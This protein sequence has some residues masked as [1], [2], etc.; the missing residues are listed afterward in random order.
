M[1][2]RRPGGAFD[3]VSRGDV[4]GAREA[5]S[6]GARA[7]PDTFAGHS[8]NDYARKQVR[9]WSLCNY[10]AIAN[11]PLIPANTDCLFDQ[12]VPTD[13]HG[14]Y[15]IVVSLPQDR[16]RNAI[17]RC[18]VAWMNW[19]TKGDDVPGGHNRLISLTMRNQLASPSFS[20]AIDKISAPGTERKVMGDY[21][22]NGTY[23]TKQHFEKHGCT[24]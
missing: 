18:G 5:F 10:G 15:T 6:A 22:P 8:R 3:E 24:A 11:P 19:T 9:H 17:A 13:S 16:P 7:H 4:E 14:Y 20:H 21:Y 23:T 2:Q 1:L 12:E